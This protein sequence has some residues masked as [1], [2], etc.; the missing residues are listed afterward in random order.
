M[1][2]WFLLHHPCRIC[3]KCLG[4][5]CL[6]VFVLSCWFGN[7]HFRVCPNKKSKASF[8]RQRRP[9]RL[10]CLWLLRQKPLSPTSERWTLS[11]VNFTVTVG[12]RICTIYTNQLIIM[13]HDRFDGNEPHKGHLQVHLIENEEYCKVEFRDARDT[14]GNYNL[15]S[16]LYPSR[17]DFQVSHLFKLLSEI[18]WKNRICF[19]CSLLPCTAGVTGVLIAVFGTAHEMRERRDEENDYLEKPCCSLSSSHKHTKII[20][21]QGAML[22]RE[23]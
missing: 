4:F 20:S 9:E 21:R 8:L 10:L 19:N 18:D 13:F 12:N 7:H 5:H 22:F 15:L 2:F 14:N 6:I 1:T 3:L 23:S 11:W 17:I 16:T